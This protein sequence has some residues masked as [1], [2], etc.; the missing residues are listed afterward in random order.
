MQTIFIK[1][2]GGYKFCIVCH[3]RKEIVN[4]QNNSNQRQMCDWGYSTV[5]RVYAQKVQDSEFSSHHLALVGGSTI[6]AP[7]DKLNKHLLLFKSLSKS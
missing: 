2:V 5:V 6:P 1:N 3:V 7:M 4:K